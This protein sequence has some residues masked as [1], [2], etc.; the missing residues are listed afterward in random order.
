MPAASA[1]V[2]VFIRR[3]LLGL[4]FAI[5]CALRIIARNAH[6]AIALDERDAAA[7]LGMR[8]AHRMLQRA[9]FAR[10]VGDGD[11]ARAALVHAPDAVL[12]LGHREQRGIHQPPFTRSSFFT[13]VTPLTRRVTASARCFVS[14]ESTTPFSVATPLSLSTL[15]RR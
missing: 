15:M 3:L 8:H 6:G 7:R 2:E 4:Y 9:P 14:C 13:S 1:K 11:A 12:G 10:E 5:V